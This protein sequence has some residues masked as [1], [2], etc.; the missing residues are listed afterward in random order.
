MS[1]SP[2]GKYHKI[3]YLERKTDKPVF[4]YVIRVFLWWSIFLD[5]K[6]IEANKSVDFLLNVCTARYDVI[7]EQCFI[8]DEKFCL[9]W[10]K[11]KEARGHTCL[12]ISPVII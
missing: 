10:L 1:Y 3:W 6:N 2:E 8:L 12:F 11:Y 9:F 5:D 4:G 7:L